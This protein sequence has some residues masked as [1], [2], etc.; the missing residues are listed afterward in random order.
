MIGYAIAL[1]A[2]GWVPLISFALLS[3]RFLLAGGASLLGI[4][5]LVGLVVRWR[6]GVLAVGL[7]PIVGFCIFALQ[8]GTPFLFCVTCFAFALHSWDLAVVS[9]GFP[10]RSH[11]AT[12]RLIH[13]YSLRAYVIAG[14]GVGLVFLV[15]RLSVELSFGTAFLGLVVLLILLRTIY[16]RAKNLIH[17]PP[18]ETEH[19]RQRRLKKKADGHGRPLEEFKRMLRRLSR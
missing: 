2:F 12:R 16:R 17:T 8:V 6:P 4:G 10:D 14:L 5:W 19:R 15:R 9:R 3:G 11:S 1:S 7:V 13:R 18:S